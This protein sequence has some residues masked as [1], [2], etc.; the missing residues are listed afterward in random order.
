MSYDKAPHWPIKLRQAHIPARFLCVYLQTVA[1]T[2]VKSFLV[3]LQNPEERSGFWSRLRYSNRTSWIT[4]HRLIWFPVSSFKHIFSL[5]WQQFRGHRRNPTLSPRTCFYIKLTELQMMRLTEDLHLDRGLR[6]L[7]PVLRHALVDAGA[8]HVGVVYGEGRHGFIAAAHENVLP[9]GEDLLPAGGVPVDVFSI[10]QNWKTENE[11]M[12]RGTN[13]SDAQKSFSVRV[14]IM[15]L[16]TSLMC[17]I[18]SFNM[19]IQSLTRHV[20]MKD[21]TQTVH[22]SGKLKSTLHES[23]ILCVTKA[24]KHDCSIKQQI[25]FKDQNKCAH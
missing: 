10:S 17:N 8:V 5:R 19:F 21:Q 16:A 2:D 14:W 12:R 15:Y 24:W 18:I 6:L 13:N 11:K 23:R 7:V 3:I 4:F 22:K 25:S 1:T 9:V 20:R